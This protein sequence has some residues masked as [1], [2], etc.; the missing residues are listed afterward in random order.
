MPSAGVPFKKGT[1][2]I[3]LQSIFILYL[4]FLRKKSFSKAAGSPAKQA[5]A[6][7]KV[8]LSDLFSLREKTGLKALVFGRSLNRSSLA[9]ASLGPCCFAA[10][11]GPGGGPSLTKSYLLAPLASAFVSLIMRQG[12]FGLSGLPCTS[13]DRKPCGRQGRLAAAQ[14]I[15]PA[16]VEGRS[17]R[18]L[19]QPSAAAA[20]QLIRSLRI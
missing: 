19:F 9:T 16:Q 2:K 5:A 11:S 14:L 8:F 4:F 12:W 3:N 18:S 20:S 10:G 13:P 1:E 17:L 7:F 6:F 15:Q